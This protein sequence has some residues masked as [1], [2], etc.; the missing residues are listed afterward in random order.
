[1]ATIKEMKEE[2]ISLRS[3]HWAMAALTIVLGIV[4]LFETYLTSYY[5]KQLSK[6]TDAYIELQKNASDLMTAS[7]YLTVEVQS[8]TVTGAKVHMDHYFEE[9]NV[10]RRREK[11]IEQMREAVGDSK[12]MHRLE[13]AMANSVEL[14]EKEY[15]AMA[16]MVRAEDIH[17]YP[18]VL[19][20][21]EI[22]PEDAA[23]EHD[24]MVLRAQALVHDN[25]YYAY[26]DNIH[27]EIAN[28]LTELEDDTH[29]V[30][31]GAGA[32]MSGRLRFIRILVIVQ[33]IGTV[34]ILLLTSY[35]CIH[36]ILG[37]VEKIREDSKIPISGSCEFRL[38]ARTYNTMFD[39]FKKSV[40]HLNYDA[41]HDKLTGLYNETGYDVIKEG[42]DAG[43]SALLLI[44]AD[45]FQGINDSFGHNT[46][47]RVLKKIADV[48]RRTFRS[49]DYICRIG[50]D[51]FAVFMQHVTPALR[52]LIENKAEFINKQ[53]MDTNDGLPECTVSI[54]VAF[55]SE[56]EQDGE[57][58]V[59]RHAE[60]ALRRMHEEGR[61][62]CCF[63]EPQ[64]RPES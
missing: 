47:E 34:L 2:G 27:G 44:D 64:S 31:T 28:C 21:V 54:G 16:L 38:L 22:T 6:A 25:A 15:Y 1:M 17:N 46:G 63:Y 53:L 51:R 7:D 62:G 36:P 9:V 11:S 3:S 45:D 13:V 57:E 41:S 30:Q 12:A 52:N 4:L 32:L 42:L 59:S 37:S 19:D 60:E 23:L 24:A 29:D 14:M 50:D 43:T 40:S 20:T 18:E 35:L 33:T 56:A 39:S 26:K 10:T 55:G 8:F 49:E 5:F 58:T 48:L 61:S